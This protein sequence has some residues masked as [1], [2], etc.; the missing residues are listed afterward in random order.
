MPCGECILIA[1]EILI[2]IFKNN[3][4]TIVRYKV[5]SDKGKPLEEKK[6][7]VNLNGS[8]FNLFISKSNLLKNMCNIFLLRKKVTSR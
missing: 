7:C 5:G 8:I 1:F 4:L 6:P 2:N 3:Y